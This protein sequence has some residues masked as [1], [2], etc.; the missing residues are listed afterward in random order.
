MKS[1]PKPA[2]VTFV[3]LCL[4]LT[5]AV[6]APLT[7]TTGGR[8]NS[9]YLFTKALHVDESGVVKIP[10]RFKWSVETSFS[11]VDTNGKDLPDSRVMLRLYDPDHN[12]TAIT[13]QMDLA[14]AAKLHHELGN[15]I[16][17]KLENP[18]YVHRPQLYDPKH[19]PTG[20]FKGVDKNGMAIIELEHASSKQAK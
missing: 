7:A 6:A 20:R 17:K 5:A 8:G 16:V 14:T 4:L 3:V 11:G 10:S 15:I 9:Y 18:R 2:L 19:I 13:A 1:F 12:F